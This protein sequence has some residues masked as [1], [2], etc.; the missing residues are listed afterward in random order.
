LSA[1]VSKEPE[2][3]TATTE[4]QSQHYVINSVCCNQNDNFVGPHQ[5]L[6]LPSPGL[7]SLA[8]SQFSFDNTPTFDPQPGANSNHRTETCPQITN[9]EEKVVVN[10]S[11]DLHNEDSFLAIWND[12][13]V[14]NEENEFISIWTAIHDEKVENDENQEHDSILR[15]EPL[16]CVTEST[17]PEEKNTTYV[18]GIL[19]S[20]G[21]ASSGRRIRWDELQLASKEEKGVMFTSCRGSSRS[22]CPLDSLI[23]QIE[24]ESTNPDRAA[25]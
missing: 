9:H 14:E 23:L 1:L 6:P 20:E 21:S 13:N 16:G 25:V 10:K 22:V 11:N 2:K 17:A 5:Y 4:L 19:R 15:V 24:K 3:T 12:I 18:K 8:S 7:G